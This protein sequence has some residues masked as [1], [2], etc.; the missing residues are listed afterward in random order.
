M[1]ITEAARRLGTTPR[2]LRYRESLGLLPLAADGPGRHRRYDDEDL[3]SARWAAVVEQRYDVSPRAL[4]F[5]L[6]SQTD[7]AVAADV[8]RLGELTGALAPATR[9]LDFDQLKA[10]RL[11]LAR[12][13]T[14]RYARLPR[15]TGP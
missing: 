11:L 5:A 13:P 14:D 10:Q 1:R 7:P 6:R 9:A 2:M 4:A 12:Q 3:A 8:R 15:R